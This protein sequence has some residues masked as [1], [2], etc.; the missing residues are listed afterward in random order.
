MIYCRTE[1]V[2]DF[3]THLTVTS[4]CSS[5]TATTMLASAMATPPEVLLYFTLGVVGG[6]LPD[7]DSDSS[8]PVRLLFTFIATVISFL[9]MF[10]QQADSTLVELFLVWAGSFVFIKFFYFL[11]L[12]RSQST[13][14]LFI[15]YRRQWL[16]GLLRPS[17]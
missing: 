2:A 12:Q 3:R 10:K 15:P 7:I 4:I 9:V 11:F 6:L 8:L 17:Y 13:G 16:S 5:I 14:A 1:K